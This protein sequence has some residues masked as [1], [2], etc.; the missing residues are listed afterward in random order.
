MDD[1]ND[2]KVHVPN[3]QCLTEAARGRC[4]GFFPKFTFNQ[5]TLKVCGKSLTIF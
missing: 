5:Q 2:I 4:K 1:P 3:Q